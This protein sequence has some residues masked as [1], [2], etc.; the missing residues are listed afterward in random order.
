MPSLFRKMETRR[1]RGSDIKQIVRILRNDPHSSADSGGIQY[2]KATAA[3]IKKL[4]RRLRSTLLS[5][6]GPLCR[7]HKGLDAHLIEEIWAWIK[8]ELETA[9]GRFLYPIIMSDIL[10]E[11]DEYRVRQLEPVVEMFITEWTLAESAPPG[12]HPIDAGT[13]WAYQ[14]NGCPACM[15]ARI[16]SDYGVLFALFAGMYGHLR[17]HS[18]GQK[19]VAKIK[20]KRL[21]FVRY[22]MRTHANG[23]Q[24]A[25]DAY[26]LGLELKTLRHDAKT[27]LRRF[28]LSKQYTRDS[29]DE[30]PVTVRHCLDEQPRAAPDISDS[31]NSKCWTITSPQDYDAKYGPMPSPDP[32]TPTVVEGWNHKPVLNLQASVHIQPPTPHS[33]KFIHSIHSTHTAES[34]T[35]APLPLLSYANLKRCDSVL[36]SSGTSLH[37]PR[38]A[39]SIY[40]S[41]SRLT[42]ATSNASYNNPNTPSTRQRG[43]DSM[44]TQEERL[45]KYRKMMAPTPSKH[46]ADCEGADGKDVVEFQGRLLPKPSRVSMYSA[47]GEEGRDGTEFEIVDETPPPSPA[48][49]GV[50]EKHFQDDDE[51]DEGD[52]EDELDAWRSDQ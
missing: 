34:D 1:L 27:S 24:A 20:S 32:A 37:S 11:A 14:K 10:S 44:E 8:F 51:D 39:S 47:F 40:S 29:L 16:G 22:W 26:D 13:K 49:E 31:Y 46:K 15:L 42:L 17:S 9:V 12:K 4:P 28:G 50:V 36:G 3:A 45:D 7:A 6:H 21:R 19:G 43:Y 23:D 25:Q 35:L 33:S 5:S 52:V 18:G 48:F 2:E 41:L 38:L 30:T